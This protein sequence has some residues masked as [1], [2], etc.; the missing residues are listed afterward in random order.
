MVVVENSKYLHCSKSNKHTYLQFYIFEKAEHK[1]T[2]NDCSV[3]FMQERVD[4]QGIGGLYAMGQSDP[5]KGRP[6]RVADVLG[7][8]RAL[9]SRK[10]LWGQGSFQTPQ[11]CHDRSAD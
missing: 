7:E 5:L 4:L 1:Y 2:E 6:G 10:R 9:G 3:C 11:G 8:K